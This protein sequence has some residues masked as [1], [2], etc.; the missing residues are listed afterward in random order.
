MILWRK[1]KKETIE[2]TCCLCDIGLMVDDLDMNILAIF[3]LNALSENNQAHV[4]IRQ[5]GFSLNENFVNPTNQ[6]TK[7]GETIS[8]SK[9]DINQPKSDKMMS[10]QNLSNS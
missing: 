3:C 1:L 9:K 2:T 10:A 7:D 8:P 4:Y 5:S 6:K